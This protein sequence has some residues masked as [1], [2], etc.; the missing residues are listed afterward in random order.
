MKPLQIV[1]RHHDG[2][3]LGWILYDQAHLIEVAS[4]AMTHSDYTGELDNLG[5]Y[6]DWLRSDLAS[7]SFY[8]I[9]P[10]DAA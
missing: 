4:E 10:E 9:E 1:E 7:L 5:A 3:V 6:L 8:E 2:R